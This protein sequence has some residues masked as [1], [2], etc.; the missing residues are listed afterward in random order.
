MRRL[1]QV[2]ALLF[3]VVL[4]EAGRFR[5][6]SGS[7]KPSLPKAPKH[8]SSSQPS[9]NIGPGG[10]PVQGGTNRV[11]PPYS[12]T[13]PHG[14]S[15]GGR[16]AP[17]GYSRT[18]PHHSPPSYESHFPRGANPNYGPPPAY[19]S[20]PSSYGFTTR[21]YPPQNGF[22]YPTSHNYQHAS[23]NGMGVYSSAP[24]NYG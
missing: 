18:N 2:S 16:V 5:V 20:K 6:F 24:N 8:T 21:N 4:A 15:V 7:R 9:G 23:Y 13:N 1:V 3:I 17:P 11:A 19:A 14:T 12:A 22:G 10:Y